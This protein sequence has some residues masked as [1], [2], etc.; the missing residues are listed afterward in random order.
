MYGL[1]T[2]IKK[3]Q[4]TSLSISSLVISNYQLAI[5]KL[6]SA[7]QRPEKKFSKLF[8]VFCTYSVSLALVYILGH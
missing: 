6:A 1:I 3:T 2:V 4:N 8:L 7:I 5:S